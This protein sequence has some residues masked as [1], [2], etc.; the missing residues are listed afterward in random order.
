MAQA[1]ILLFLGLGGLWALW[2]QRAATAQDFFFAALAVL[3]CAGLSLRFAR[4]RVIPLGA[5]LKA[6][7]VFAGRLGQSWRDAGAV[8]S[9]ALSADVKLRPSLVRVRL[10]GTDEA[11]HAA[12]ANLVTASPGAASVELDADGLLVHV[13]REDAI[14]ARDLGRLEASLLGA[15]ASTE[16]R[17]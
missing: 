12:L 9:A 14:D 4:A 1:A 2:V 17:P 8:M 5:A 16:V 15:P 13:L 10:R 7:A 6:F 3:A 11:R